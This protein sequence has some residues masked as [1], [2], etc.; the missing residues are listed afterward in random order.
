[1]KLFV[2]VTVVALLAVPMLAAQTAKTAK[3][4]TAAARV[5]RGKYLVEDIGLCGDCHTPRDE[6]GEPVKDQWL[7]GASLDF[8]PIAAV[9]VWADKAPAIAGLPGWEEG[10]AIKFL[11]TGFAYN[12]LPRRPP[13]PQY[14]FNVQDAQA[15]VAYLK[16]LA[17]GK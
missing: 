6:K 14:R 10:A 1:M 17:L 13:M 12:G 7:K 11:M 8:K 5:A 3:S 9:P 15:I 4:R 2:A 16:S